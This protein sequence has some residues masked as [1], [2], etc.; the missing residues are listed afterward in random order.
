MIASRPA[1][2]AVPARTP[3]GSPTGS[4]SAGTRWPARWPW[5][6]WTSSRGRTS[7]GTYARTR[8][9]FRSYLERLLDLPIVGDVRGDGYFYGIEL[10]KDK[11]TRETFDDDESERLL[12]G[13]PVQGA[14]RRRALLPGRR[15]GRPGGP[16]RAAAD[17]RREPV[18]RDGADPA[19]R[20]DRGL[21]A[22][23]MH[24]RSRTGCPLWR[25]TSPRGRRC[26]ATPTSTWRSSAPATP[27]CGRPT[28]WPGADP[29]A[30][31]RRAR[32]RDR[33]VRR[34]GR[35]GGWCSAL[36]PQS[37]PALARRHGR[38][39]AIALHR[40]MQSTVDEVGRVAA[41]EGI[42]C[43]YAKGGTR[44]AGPQR[45]SSWRR[46]AG[47]GRASPRVRLRRRR[48]GPAR[49]SRGGRARCGATRV[50][51]GTYTPHCAAIH[52]A[53]LVRGLARAVER[54]G[55]AHLRA[56]AGSRAIEPRRG[57]TEP[58]TVRARVVVR[59]TEGYTAA[60][61]PASGRPWPRSTR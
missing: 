34:L 5:P 30:A 57:H 38:D 36:F 41:A 53:D 43:H 21:D 48:P 7:T 58:G 11:A 9:L 55:V 6:T 49:T 20:A 52:P 24:D 40:A 16:A 27:G 44:R 28:T 12:R 18:R 33:R 47:R 26:P 1:G 50:L 15:P 2:R 51:G 42:D 37:L 35:N 31:D 29:G 54:R 60:A 10:V 4:P 59:A 32:G 61:A 23:L 25:T 46:A 56:H 13:L 14:V 39:R 3:T 19:R 22:H 17:L 45:R 8:R